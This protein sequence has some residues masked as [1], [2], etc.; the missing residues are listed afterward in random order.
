MH[1]IQ[2][3]DEMRQLATSWRKDGFSIG[4]VPTMGAL[5][6]GHV[7]LIQKARENQRVI[8]SIFVNPRQFGAN[9][10]FSRYPRKPHEDCAICKK[11]GV[12]AV[13]MPHAD[14]LYQYDDGIRILAPLAMSNVLEGAIRPGHFDGVLE[15]LTRFFHIIQPTRA[16][17]GRKDAQQLLI[18]QRMVYEWF[19]NLEII[20]CEIIRDAH[21]IALS[22]RNAYLSDDGYRNAQKIAQSTR[23]LEQAIKA[24]ECDFA[25]LKAKSLTILSPLEID[26]FCAIDYNLKE[27]QTLTKHNLIVKAVRIEGV[28]L[29]DSVWIL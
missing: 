9:E 4:F 18:V 29:L 23:F 14:A 22:S 10:D 12:D 2:N 8:V 24:G 25:K 16:Y 28:R 6:D 19:W 21:G 11:H 20:G 15:V 26:Y 3:I 27:V 5:H 17:F 7:S 1:C 13:F